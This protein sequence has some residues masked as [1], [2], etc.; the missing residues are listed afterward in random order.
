MVAS[1]WLG[2]RN[3][4]CQGQPWDPGWTAVT[5]FCEGCLGRMLAS[6]GCGATV[7]RGSGEK[8]VNYFAEAV[9]MAYGALVVG[10]AL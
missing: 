1:C 2:G 6:V 10:A 9:A 4:H 8:A 3:S 5:A 7:W